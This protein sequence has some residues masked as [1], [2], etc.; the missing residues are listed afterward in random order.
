MTSLIS[1]FL[2]KNRIKSKCKQN[3]SNHSTS[4]WMAEKFRGSSSGSPSNR[5]RERER[6]DERRK[7]GCG[8]KIGET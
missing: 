8:G 1:L 5:R 7:R 2:I 3:R 6:E 4:K